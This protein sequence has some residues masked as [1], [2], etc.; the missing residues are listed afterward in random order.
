M[1]GTDKPPLWLVVALMVLGLAAFVGAAWYASVPCRPGDRGFY[2][3][4]TMLMAGCPLPHTN[5]E[6]F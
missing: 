6:T 4:A 3:G 5:A 1:S 2:I